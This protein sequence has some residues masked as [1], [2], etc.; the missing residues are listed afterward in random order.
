MNALYIP[1]KLTQHLLHQAQ[2][3]PNQEICGLVGG[4]NDTATSVYP[5][6]NISECPATRFELDPKQQIA[7]INAM[8]E[9]GE[10]LLAIYHSHPTASA[11][12]SQHDIQRANYPDAIYLIISLNTKGVLEMRGFHIKSQQ[13]KEIDL[14]MTP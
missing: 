11:E 7:A 9:K 4:H 10:Q 8:R 6:D 13:I 5:I 12:P 1:R 3:S 2:I 14:I